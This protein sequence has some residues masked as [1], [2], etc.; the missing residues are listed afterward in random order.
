[1]SEMRSLLIETAQRLFTKLCTEQVH[2]R[3]EEGE[4]QP[5]LWAALEESGLPDAARSSERGGAGEDL[6]DALAIVRESGTA[7]LPAPVIETMLAERVLAAAGLASRSGPLTIGP[8]VATDR[9][10]LAPKG[11]GWVLSGTLH[12][13]PWA[14]YTGSVV[15]VASTEQGWATALVEGP[16]VINLGKNF[17]NEPRDD[18]HFD[19]F[20]LAAGAVAIN[21]GCFTV[22]DLQ[23]EGAL[24]R[25]V[26]MTGAL[27]RILGLT[28]EYA[29][30]RVQFG[31]PIA[32]FQAVQHQIAVM[33]S[34]VAAASAAA[35][36]V[37]ESLRHGAARFDIAAAKARI[38]EA[39]GVAV[40]IAHQLHGAMGF[41][42]EYA[43]HRSTRRLW[44][45]RDE[46][47]SENEWSSWI[48]T[49]VVGLGAEGLWPFLTSSRRIPQGGFPPL[50]EKRA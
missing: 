26:A 34:E 7:A 3:A 9:V 44:S 40:A 43:L 49:V 11:D 28:L 16:P 32:K 4:W 48:G 8:V 38:G 13:V 27:T 19:A 18:I 14:R 45:W 50:S 12:R 41:T 29:T 5:S 46:F 17:A 20:P 30:Q 22:E 2:T 6:G 37:I 31:S 1:M 47:G 35:D 33:S 39:A 42:H 24:F 10:L 25:L 15:V 21:G 36:A 23:F